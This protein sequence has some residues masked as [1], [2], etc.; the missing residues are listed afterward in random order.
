MLTTSYFG[1]VKQQRDIPRYSVNAPIMPSPSQAAK[2]QKRRSKASRSIP[3][4]T[5]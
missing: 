3:F 5:I 4:T 2:V 1:I